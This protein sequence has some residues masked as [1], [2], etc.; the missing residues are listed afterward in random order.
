MSGGLLCTFVFCQSENM[1][2][3]NLEGKR[4]VLASQSPRRKQLFEGLELQFETIALDV[5]ES[6]P[7]HLKGPDIA[8]YLSRKKAAAVHQ[9]LQ[10]NEIYITADTIVWIN[11]HVLN[12]PANRNEAITMLEELS[13]NSHVVFTAVTVTSIGKEVTLV[14][15]TTV[16]FVKLDKNEIEYYVD[17]YKPYDKAGAYGV[18]ELIGYIAIQKLEGSYY[19]VMGLPVHK[20]YKTLKDF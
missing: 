17:H 8:E 12:K 14:D 19:N 5:D 2:L 18:Q 10:H 9:D 7:S 1:I 4:V 16:E 3:K 15:S 6:F 20:L 11:D 13:G